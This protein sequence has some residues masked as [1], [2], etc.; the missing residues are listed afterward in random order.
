MMEAYKD[1]R[2]EEIPQE[3]LAEVKERCKDFARHTPP[4][5]EPANDEEQE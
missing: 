4:E 1:G 3:L 5:P 2:V